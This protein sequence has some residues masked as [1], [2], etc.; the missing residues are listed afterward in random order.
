MNAGSVGRTEEP[1]S[2]G[3]RDSCLLLKSQVTAVGPALPGVLLSPWEKHPDSSRFL[4]GPAASTDSQGC[5][6][7]ALGAGLAVEGP[8]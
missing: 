4:R 1:E 3:M 8:R 6:E 5:T 7:E 2:P